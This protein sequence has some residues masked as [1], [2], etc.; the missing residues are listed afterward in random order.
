MDVNKEIRFVLKQED[1][2]FYERI[3]DANQLNPITRNTIDIRRDLFDIIKKIQNVLSRKKV[4]TSMSVGENVEYD[5]YDYH[6]KILKTHT[7]DQQVSLKYKPNNVKKIFNDKEF[8]GVCFK[9]GMYINENTIVERVFYVSD[10]NP[11]VRWSVDLL[12]VMNEIVDDIYKSLIKKDVT[13]IWEDFEIITKSGLTIGRV[14]EMSPKERNWW[15]DRKK[16]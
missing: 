4:E 15:L 13:N 12:V 8:I 6:K 7:K 14:R 5:F 10:F 16:Y 11:V 2:V 3:V 1:I 9:F